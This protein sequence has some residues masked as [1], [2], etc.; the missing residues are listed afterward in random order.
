M[1]KMGRVAVLMN[2]IREMK[3]MRCSIVMISFFVSFA[4]LPLP[5][6]QADDP[7][8][9]ISLSTGLPGAPTVMLDVVASYGAPAVYGLNGTASSTQ[10]TFPPT[11]LS[12][13]LSGTANITTT[14]AVEISLAGTAEDA[15]CECIKEV[16]FHV[17][18]DGMN[19]RY[20]QIIRNAKDGATSILTGRAEIAQSCGN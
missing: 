16:V 11:K 13:V 7:N 3:V 18:F 19:D 8:V 4:L 17:V 20:T 15:T 12:Y 10:A 5:A 6:A 1:K 9:C 2:R 14:Q